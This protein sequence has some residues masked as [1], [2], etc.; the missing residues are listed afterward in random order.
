M[1]IEERLERI[2]EKQDLILS[3]IGAESSEMT[4]TDIA[5]MCGVSR[6]SLYK[7]KRYLLPNFGQ[8]KGRKKYRRVDV[9]LWLSKGE[10]A[11][12]KEWKNF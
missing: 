9:L 3:L 11:L 8:E 1:G 5:K 7:D 2:E 6:Q 12:R 4:V 10:D